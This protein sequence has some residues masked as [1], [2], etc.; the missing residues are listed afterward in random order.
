MILSM[1]LSNMGQKSSVLQ[2]S[3]GPSLTHKVMEI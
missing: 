1:N 3:A 2:Y